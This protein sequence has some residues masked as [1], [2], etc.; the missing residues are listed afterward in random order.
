M[1][2]GLAAEPCGPLAQAL[3]SPLLLS[4]AYTAYATESG[5]DP[6]ELAD[7]VTLSNAA[8]I[9]AHL[10]DALLS[11]A[12]RH[13]PAVRHAFVW[14]ARRWDEAKSRHWLEFLARRLKRLQ[15][16]DLAWWQ[17]EQDGPAS[18][19]AWMFAVAAWV[20]FSTAI[21]LTALVSGEAVPWGFVW[22]GG[23]PIGGICCLVVWRGVEARKR[24]HYRSSY[25][26]LVV[27][28]VLAAATVLIVAWV[29]MGSR[30]PLVKTALSFAIGLGVF[31]PIAVMGTYWDH[32]QV[33]AESVSPA[34][35]MARERRA[36]LIVAA[37]SALLI[38]VGINIVHNGI[39]L[40]WVS[41]EVPLGF[42][43]A[44]CA[45]GV[46][47]WSMAASRWGIY[48][49]A[50]ARLALGGKLPWRLMRFLNDAHHRGVLRQEGS[51]Y[52][53]RHARLQE[54]LIV[55][56]RTPES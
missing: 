47:L 51:V 15:A 37:A 53:F 11:T 8:A 34:V 36:P 50:H 21:T 30:L 17:L 31:I 5:R 9:E 10:L 2:D 20:C 26:S 4:L 22:S 13:E 12:F 56:G 41:D 16:P 48:Q 1:L 7:T 49:V 28:M 42:R 29:A 25:S 32:R 6:A 46:A 33:D 45:V 27:A 35:L 52:Q 19:N 23:G 24:P 38:L 54:R 18:Q 14:R 43:F 40:P 39:G 3:A 44:Q 55:S